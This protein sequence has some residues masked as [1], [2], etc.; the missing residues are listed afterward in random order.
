MHGARQIGLTACL[1]F[2]IIMHGFVLAGFLHVP[3]SSPDP[4]QIAP[5]AGGSPARAAKIRRVAEY[6]R[7]KNA[8]ELRHQVT[9]LRDVLEELRQFRAEQEQAVAAFLD[10]QKKD[11]PQRARAAQQRI[12]ELQDKVLAAQQQHLA[13]LAR[14]ET[15]QAADEHPQPALHPD[16]TQGRD[17]AL[18]AQAEVDEKQADALRR[19]KLAYAPD[20][21]P[22]AIQSRAIESQDKANALQIEAA[23][24][25]YDMHTLENRLQRL[26]RHKEQLSSDQEQL[27]ALLAAGAKATDLTNGLSARLRR[28]LGRQPEWRAAT[29]RQQVAAPSDV[30]PILQT[31]QAEYAQK[32]MAVQRELAEQQS[33][34]GQLPV[35]ITALVEAALRAQ[36]EA[37]AA[38]EHSYSSLLKAIETGVAPSATSNTLESAGTKPD[39]QQNTTQRKPPDKMDTLYTEAVQTEREIAETFRQIRAMQLAMMLDI[40]I[41]EALRMTEKPEPPGREPQKLAF[42]RTVN[43]VE[44]LDALGER[45]NRMFQETARIRLQCA[46]LQKEARKMAL[47]GRRGHR[48][49]TQQEAY[50]LARP[51]QERARRLTKQPEFGDVAELMKAAADGRLIHTEICPDGPG[52]GN[53]DELAGRAPRLWGSYG[54]A[55]SAGKVSSHGIPARWIYL[56]SWYTIGPFPNP[57]RKNINRRFP[58]ELALDLDAG[59]EGKDG[60]MIRWEFVN[61][62]GPRILPYA[63]EPFGVYYAYTEIAFEQ[64]MDLWIAVGADDKMHVWINDFLVYESTERLKA[65]RIDEAMYKVHFKKGTNRILVRVENGR[66]LIAY[67]VLLYLQKS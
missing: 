65:W 53:A 37:K 14:T 66:A 17:Q 33:M 19:L 47:L 44:D 40:P 48:L 60:R 49:K 23:R 39:A 6:V 52:L 56:N 64:A 12:I 36:A 62:D 11:A 35:R 34:A 63:A 13:A 22:V 1:A 61:T 51:E 57:Q 26:S 25:W 42:D 31:K 50:Q 41:D 58:P 27:D 7:E 9:E 8:Q 3:A 20:S 28:E 55:P 45:L 67:S 18:Q 59:Y 15:E 30:T 4:A 5:H 38:Q 29:A 54:V 46:L 24:Y 21:E 16:Q 10:E 32:L 43:D 2:S